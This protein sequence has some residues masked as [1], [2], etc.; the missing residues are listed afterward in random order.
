MEIDSFESNENARP[1]LS[2]SSLVRSMKMANLEISN[3][4]QMS[5]NEDEN[6]VT[7]AVVKQEKNGP[8]VDDVNG[9][10]TNSKKPR[11]KQKVSLKKIAIRRESG[12]RKWKG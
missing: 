1:T 7:E 4:Q 8:V 3:D 9:T 2:T 6:I 11:K 12:D 5:S 10:G